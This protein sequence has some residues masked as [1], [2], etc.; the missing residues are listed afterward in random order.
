MARAPPSRDCGGGVFVPGW[1]RSRPKLEVS[2]RQFLTSAAL[3]RSRESLVPS[4]L[5][6]SAS[7]GRPSPK[8]FT[9]TNEVSVHRTRG[10]WAVSLGLWLLVGALG[11]RPSEAMTVHPPGYSVSLFRNATGNS[12]IDIDAAGSFYLSLG[13]RGI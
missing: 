1:I 3:P 4:V 6:S 12:D 10:S 11:A 2:P 8:G 7:T 5:K 9:F 13:S